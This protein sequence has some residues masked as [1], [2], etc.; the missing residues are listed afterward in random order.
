RLAATTRDFVALA[1]FSRARCQQ[2][3][4]RQDEAALDRLGDNRY[5]VWADP[6]RLQTSQQFGAKK[7]RGAHD[8]PGQ[9]QRSLV[10]KFEVGYRCANQGCSCARGFLHNAPSDI[11]AVVSRVDDDRSQ[12]GDLLAQ[13]D[14]PAQSARDLAGMLY[15]QP[16]ADVL[17]ECSL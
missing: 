10:W 11:V 14:R 7:L 16:F 12:R 4:P 6:E 1:A 15:L 8:S 2:A 5:R 17:H 3:I 9:R 13:V